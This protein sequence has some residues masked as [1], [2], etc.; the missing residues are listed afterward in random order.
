MHAFKGYAASTVFHAGLLY[1]LSLVAQFSPV[2][3]PVSSGRA[4]LQVA[5]SAASRKETPP[6]EPELRPKPEQLEAELTEPAEPPAEPIDIA[7]LAEAEALVPAEEIPRETEEALK[8]EF[9]DEAEPRP[10]PE[11]DLD[12]R[13]PVP[14]RPQRQAE[15]DA[16]AAAPQVAE[17]ATVI[18]ATTPVART[19]FKPREPV[20]PPATTEQVQPTPPRPD[21]DARLVA[22]V[23]AIASA[24]SA[25]SEGAQTDTDPT[26]VVNP[27]PPYPA[28]ALRAGLQGRVILRVAVNRAGIV[29]ALQ[30][31]TS[32]GS[33]SLD[34]A[35]AETVRRWRFRP[36]T[37]LGR[38]TATTVLI[39]VRFSIRGQ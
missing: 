7:M 9:L 21:P 32:S 38:P 25:G 10:Q 8:Q 26:L 6:P 35:A 22:M 16:V 20:E 33:A 19:S 34:S 37:R 24:P 13:D 15:A 1:A 30:V 29:D 4:S 12:P 18:P 2:A 11:P 3:L 39:P 36:A 5:A 17:L 27:A 14:P 23:D 28:D 31:E